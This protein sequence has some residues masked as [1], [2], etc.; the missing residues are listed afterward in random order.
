MT[1]GIALQRDPNAKTV[2]HME[3]RV[4]QRA[5]VSTKNFI[6]DGGYTTL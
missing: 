2:F 6:N 3:V 5:L 4:L 1:S